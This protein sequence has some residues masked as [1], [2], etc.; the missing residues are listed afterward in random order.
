MNEIA[1]AM[2]HEDKN[3]FICF[4][5]IMYMHYLHFKRFLFDEIIT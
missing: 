1:I 3:S 5:F 4:F 2:P